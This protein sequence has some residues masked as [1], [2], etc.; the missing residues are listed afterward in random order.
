MG[1]EPSIMQTPRQRFAD[2]KPYEIVDR[3]EDLQGPTTGII[4][5]S[6]RL[7]WV[8]YR[9]LDLSTVGG[10]RVLVR[11]VIDNGTKEDQARYLSGEVIQSVWDEML[12]PPPPP[13]G[14]RRRWAIKFPDKLS[15]AGNYD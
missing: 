10:R 8:P 2:S 5:L 4:T 3:W 13:P 1:K 11:E 12:L 7:C 6:Q 14:T 15:E 9:T